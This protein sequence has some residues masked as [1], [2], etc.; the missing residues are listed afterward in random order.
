[1]GCDWLKNGIILCSNN[2]DANMPTLT[3]F[4]SHH[5]VVFIDI[6]GYHNFCYAVN[7]CTFERIQ[8]E[9]QSAIDYLNNHNIN[10]FQV[11]FINKVPF[12]RHFDHLVM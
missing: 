11:L 10:S 12:Y 1:M 2:D 6:T 8:Q 4:H 9:A 7:P 3:E 5:K